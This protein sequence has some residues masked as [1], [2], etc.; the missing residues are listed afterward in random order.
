MSFHQEAWMQLFF[1][2]L[3]GLTVR[4]WCQDMSAEGRL[5]SYH[6]IQA[7]H[8]H[9]DRRRRF[10]PSIVHG[11]LVLLARASAHLQQRAQG[12]EGRSIAPSPTYFAPMPAGKFR[13]LLSAS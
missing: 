2:Y 3:T 9:R 5:Q 7:E 8:H 1:Q 4:F 11:G 13:V 12:A 6:G 10:P